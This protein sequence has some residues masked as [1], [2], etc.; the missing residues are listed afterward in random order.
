MNRRAV[1]AYASTGFVGGLSG[2]LSG[3]IPVGDDESETETPGSA[4]TN[5]DMRLSLTSMDEG[6]GPMTFDIDVVEDQLT[7]STVPL[8]DISVENTGDEKATWLYRPTVGENED[9]A[10]PCERATPDKLT[11]GLE[12]EVTRLLVDDVGCARTETELDRGDVPLEAELVP[13]EA[14]EQRYAIAGYE[15]K[16]DGACPPAETY[17]IDCPYEDHGRWGFEIELMARES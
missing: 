10:F 9:L 16:L 12:P 3:S 4:D 5:T 17:R 6:P 14:V 13:G 1:L 15:P 8:L 11:I 2:C 7:S